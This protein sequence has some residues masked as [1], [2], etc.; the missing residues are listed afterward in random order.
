MLNKKYVIILSLLGDPEV[1]VGV[2]GTGGFNKT[3]G[4][5]LGIL[6][7]TNKNIIVITNKNKYK[8]NNG[9]FISNNIYIYRIDF[10]SCWESNQ[11]SL[12]DNIDKITQRVNIIISSIRK[13]AEICL[14]HSFYW[15]SGIIASKI[16]DTINI[17]FIHTVVS[18]SEDKYSSGVKPHA[19]LQ[20]DLE[21]EFLP[22]AEFIFAITPQEKNTLIKK[23]NID[24]SMIQVVGRSIDECFAN[25]YQN[26]QEIQSLDEKL[27]GVDLFNDYSWWVNGAFLYVGRIVEIK[28]IRQIVN[29]WIVA[30]EKYDINI[31]LWLVGGTPQQIYKIRQLIL[32]DHPSIAKYEKEKQLMW[33]GNLNSNGIS[34]LMR[35]TQTLIMHSRFEAGGRVIIEAF[36][37]GIPVIAT[38]YGFASDY[39]FNGYNGFITEFNDVEYLAKVMNRFSIQPYLS[40]VMG[41]NAYRFMNTIQ[42][43]WN[44]EKSH[45][46]VYDAFICKTKLPI[47][48]DRSFLPHD[49]N[50]FKSR[51][52]V[53]VFPYFSTKIKKQTLSEIINEKIGKCSINPIQNDSYHSDLYLINNK[54]KKYYL[55]SFYHIIT[56]RLSKLQYKNNDVIS[57]QEQALK[58]INSANL[59]NIANIKFGDPL[60]LFYIIPYYKHISKISSLNFL[61]SLWKEVKPSDYYIDLY[62]KKDFDNLKLLIDSSNNPML[63]YLFCAELAYKELFIR[64]KLPSEI[65]NKIKEIM[66][67]NENAIFGLNYGKEITEHIVMVDSDIKL[68][69]AHSMFIGELGIDLVLTFLQCDQ[70]DIY[71]WSSIKSAQNIV[72]TAR[73]DL[74]FLIVVYALEKENNYKSII[75]KILNL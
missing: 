44:Y 58:S 52:C 68:L 75:K 3:V 10:D 38:P 67:R 12:V 43:N 65:D 30:K 8:N 40:S 16:K 35:R 29:A 47:V 49:L 6:S 57:A 53:I 28:G 50:S 17:P 33:W 15:I 69:P 73:L 63:N 59:I 23:Y 39:I 61:V 34:T 46:D 24:K 51:N 19:A 45:F 64:Y 66:N 14:I 1:L 20:R 2:P 42:K 55:K 37:A 41:A 4:E 22:K 48:I 27:S 13:E 74:W 5:L 31:P 71:L 11:N 70:D 60:K 25:A 9:N 36:S 18:L 32:N 72:C 26:N 62:L 21:A 54:E 7:N 56:N